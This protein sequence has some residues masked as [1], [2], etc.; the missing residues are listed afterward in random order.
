VVVLF[1]DILVLDNGARFHSV[2]LHIHSYGASQ[3]V[4]DSTMTPE[5][6]VDSAVR[7]GLI[8][9]AI[10]DHNSNVNVQRAIDHAQENYAGQI[11]VLPGV[12]VTTAHGH[13]L[14]YFAPD[15]TADLAKLLSRLDLIGEMGADNTRTAKS[16]A[17]TIAEVEKIG[18]ICIAA[19]IDREKTGFDVFANGFQNWKKDIIISPGL[20]G[21]ECDAVDALL[22]YS[23]QDEAGSAGVER[24]K[25]LAARKMVK[26]LSARHHLAHVQG[27]DAH[28]MNWFEHQAPSKPWTRIK[29]AELSFN[30]LRV[31]LIDPTARVR[32]CASVP[33]SIPRVHGVAITGGFLHQETIH[34]S[35]N[36]NCL[37]GGRGTGKS[38][39]IRAIAYA[40]GLNDEFGD[41]DNCPDSVT[42]FCEDEN[43]ILYRYVRTR[44]GDI[45][46]KAKEDASITDVP[47]DAFR[48]E[49][50]GQG[51]LAKVAEDPLKH[52]DLFQ[53]FLDRH[54]NLRDLVETEKSLVTSLRENAGRLSPLESAFG[55]L[56]AKKKSLEEIEKKLKVA[57]E[58]NLREVV[59]T[60]SKLASEKAVRESIEAIAAEY[61]NGWV[62]SSI[63]RG[64]DQIVA[65]AGTCTED[66]ASNITMAAI[67]AALLKNN[68][69]VKQKE[70]E[71]NALLKSCA[72][73]LT[74]LARE[75]KVSHQRMSGEVATKLAD[76][77]ARGLV[78]DIPGLEFL[79]RQKT[80]VAKEI[81]GVEQRTD[82]RKQCRE[83]RT[84]LLEKLREVREKMTAR[85]KVQLKGINANL[86]WTIKDYT[87][88]VK[89]DNAGITGEFETFI[90]DK[91]H[92]TYLQDN[93]IENV[94][95]RITPSELADLI[96]ER[97]HQKIATTAK[98]SIEW[99][100]K[101]V[102]K[103]CYWPIL[104]ELQALAKQPK[105]IITV[106]TK[107]TPPKE[108]PVLQLSDGQ[109]HTILLTIAM[110]AESN[111][112]LL[113]DQPEDDLDNAFIFSSIV[114]TLRAI[115][116]R[117][118]VILVTHNA[119]I[120]V[121]GDS[122]L[123]LPMCR[124]NDCG[125]TKDR[126]SIDTDATK[127][128]VLDIL[129][130]GP[131]AFLRRKEMYSH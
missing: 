92:G 79:L 54:T 108:I 123:I 8:V 68:A 61:T 34:F 106:R 86:G 9:I 27:S 121:L 112:P 28:S 72:K 47:I 36:L 124:E 26:G 39:A 76:L 119:N 100:E 88:F 114:T 23:E 35:D 128:C 85:R 38:T 45:E 93:L 16:M 58:G 21:L 104:F 69:A 62:L 91:M 83:Q 37:I 73:E 42:V 122:E 115:K 30:A 6:I 77:K 131:D 113:I 78:T 109:R 22:W 32:A 126:G 87:I 53:E 117:R 5:A 74:K 90:Q 24:K 59:G 1:K 52:P 48:I 4:K 111:V 103:L 13:L 81:S 70:L 11:L 130:G 20:Y 15:R 66:E 18:G 57:E 43:G 75:L 129:E 101:I 82:E 31:A 64:F 102:D 7:Q 25:M 60:Q 71:L 14:A 120:A 40:F 29:L 94:C 3:D 105:P 51:E 33:C 10:T 107:S 125:K 17:D 56:T 97:N 67:K 2:D 98:V 127:R 95:S 19:H 96:L 46:V 110:L 49:F 55:Q 84:K 50:F 89:Y 118:Q 80:S 12:E 99:A 44:G 65:T 63:Q 41:Y 116:E